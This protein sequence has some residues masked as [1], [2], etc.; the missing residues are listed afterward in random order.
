MKLYLSTISLLVLQSSTSFQIN[1]SRAASLS[2][3]RYT[4][5]GAP[6]EEMEED[7]Q[8]V[9]YVQQRAA[10]APQQAHNGAVMDLSSY[11]DYD[12]VLEDDDEL[13]VDSFSPASGASI[14]PGFHL[15]ALCGDD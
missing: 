4:V 15:S 5:I 10:A 6:G 3:L 2:A 14:M 11:R 7:P 12:D 1:P 9:G 8:G 13:N